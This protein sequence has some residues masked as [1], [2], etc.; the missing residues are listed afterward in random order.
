MPNLCIL[1]TETAT[2]VMVSNPKYVGAFEFIPPFRFV[3]ERRVAAFS[4]FPQTLL[5]MTPRLKGGR[6]YP[7]IHFKCNVVSENEFQHYDTNAT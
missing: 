2:V 6:S 4:E 7:A 5:A 3:L 1:H